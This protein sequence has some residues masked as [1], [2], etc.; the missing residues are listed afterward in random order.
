MKTIKYKIYIKRN[1]YIYIMYIYGW[2]TS[3]WQYRHQRCGLLLALSAYD[4][5]I[6]QQNGFN[7][8]HILYT[9]LINLLI[10]HH[11]EMLISDRQTLQL[12][13]Q[14]CE[15]CVSI[16]VLNTLFYILFNKPHSLLPICINRII[17]RAQPT[18]KN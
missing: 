1:T 11:I 6:V 16:G 5:A 2:M 10:N 15:M 7:H 13:R 14:S 12:E 8:W 3:R 9:Y 18:K 4:D 17:S